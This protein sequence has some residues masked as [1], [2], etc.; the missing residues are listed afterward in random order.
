MVYEPAE[1]SY[2]LLDCLNKELDD[3]VEKDGVS[4]EDRNMFLLDMGSGSG[5]IG[6]EAAKK[7]CHVT[8]VD[9]DPDAVS[10]MEKNKPSSDVKIILSDFFEEIE[11]LKFD[12]LTFNAPYL[13][14][15]EEV[16][17]MALHGGKEGYEKTV[18]FL[19]EARHYMYEDS[20][21]LLLI[22]TLTKADLVETQMEAL[23]YKYEVIGRKKEFMEELL[24]YRI[25][26]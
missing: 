4:I 22:S 24:V 21:I 3:L 17:D 5:L 23:K 1:D 11:G 14:N 26:K 12:V 10:L 16:Q 9:V 20:V 25:T 15:D 19:R 8:C 2:L 7:G 6:F 13:P 18:K